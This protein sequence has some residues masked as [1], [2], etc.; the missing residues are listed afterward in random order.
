[1]ANG[2]LQNV[3]ILDL[4]HVWAGPLATRMLSDLGAQ[5]LKIEAPMGRGPR[6]YPATP[7]GHFI[8]GSPGDEPWNTNAVF[9]KLMRNKKSVAVN[10]KDDTG[11]KTF[12]SLVSVS[13]VVIENFSARAMKGLRLD[14]GHLKA[15]NPRIIHVAMPGYGLSGLYS[16]RVAFG[17]TVEPMSGLS[18]VM[19]YGEDEPR[20]TAMAMPDPTSAVNATAAVVTA[21]KLRESTGEGRLVEMSL[22]ESAV[23][24]SGPWLIDT[25][26]GNPSSRIGN[27]HPEMVPHGIFPCRETDSWLA[28]GCRNQSEYESLCEVGNL[29]VDSSWNLDERRKNEDAIEAAI[30]S[31]THKQSYEHVSE[32]LVDH[33][34]PVG[35]VLDT[36]GMFSNPQ[37]ISRQFFVPIE[38]GTPIPGTPVKM[39]SISINDWTPCPKL[40][41]H[42]RE[43]LSDWLGYDDSEIESLYEDGIIV[44]K[45]PR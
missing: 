42:N 31:W 40:G 11:R 7:I 32:A 36:E 37:T 5:V 4:T 14:Y 22:H 25:Q 29:D 9:V 18:S 16:D 30:R 28:I 19:G 24:Y 44:D 45:P 12:L 17:P 34:I 27:R 41:E 35:R 10:L 23:S 33:N 1:M 39:S 8:G 3:R 15:V 20:V 26:L 13:D 38:Q 2:P 43:V 6:H 21:L